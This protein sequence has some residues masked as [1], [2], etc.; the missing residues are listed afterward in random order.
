MLSTVDIGYITGM[1][2]FFNQKYV[3]LA[4]IYNLLKYIYIKNYT[5]NIFLIT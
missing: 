2:L 4:M 1:S 5:Y 3:L